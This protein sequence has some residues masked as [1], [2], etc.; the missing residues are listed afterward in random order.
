MTEVIVPLLMGRVC[1]PFTWTPLLPTYILPGNGA[2][3][4]VLSLADGVCASSEFAWQIHFV[5]AA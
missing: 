1:C 2:P 4:L 3:D 5:T